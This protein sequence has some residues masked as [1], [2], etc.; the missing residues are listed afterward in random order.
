M[1]KKSD[2]AN[3]ERFVD[4]VT[5]PVALL[6][7]GI[8]IVSVISFVMH[9]GVL[10]KQTEVNNMSEWQ[11]VEDK[12]FRFVNEGDTIEGKYLSNELSTLYDNKVYKIE[13]E[14][15][16]YTIFG[17]TILESKMEKV[18]V[19]K[20]VKIVFTGTQPNKNRN[21]SDIKLFD[22]FTK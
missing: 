8:V 17:T 11:K 12:I 3:N 14:E 20:M 2:T 4:S 18:E 13:T 19:G 5:F 10:E 15:G 6:L 1:S 22:V 7:V 9:F 16:V 21:Q